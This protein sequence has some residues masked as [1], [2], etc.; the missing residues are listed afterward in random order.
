MGGG[1]KE[2]GGMA[3]LYGLACLRSAGSK[4]RFLLLRGPR[5]REIEDGEARWQNS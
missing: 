1:R 5:I 2:G 4:G 3:R